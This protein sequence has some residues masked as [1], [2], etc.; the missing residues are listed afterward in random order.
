[1]VNSIKKKLRCGFP[2]ILLLVVSLGSIVYADDYEYDDNGRVVS[3]NHDDGSITSY[4]YDKNGNI[5]NVTTIDSKLNETPSEESINHNNKY[6]NEMNDTKN[7]EDTVD[8]TNGSSSKHETEKNGEKMLEKEGD[9]PRNRLQKS[10]EK[11]L[12]GDSFMLL[13]VMAILLISLIVIIAIIYK[14]K[15]GRG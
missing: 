7:V 11:V 12:T 14:K 6:Q 15:K 1:M 9:V 2:I 5:I 3:V 13:S 8:G 10:V 4:E